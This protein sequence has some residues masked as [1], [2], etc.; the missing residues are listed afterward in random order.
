MEDLANVFITMRKLLCC[1]FLVSISGQALA[2]VSSQITEGYRQGSLDYRDRT[3]Y[4]YDS[5]G[6]IVL[7]D[8]D[9]WHGSQWVD[10][11]RN[12]YVY[13]EKGR[14]IE[15]TSFH[16][17]R[18][19]WRFG[20]R[21]TWWFS[22]DGRAETETVR[23]WE[24]SEWQ[25]LFQYTRTRDD[26]GRLLSSNR[27]F[28]IA[29]E[30]QNGSIGQHLTSTLRL[31]EYTQTGAVFTT[32]IWR[33]GSWNNSTRS[34][35]EY[36]ELGRATSSLYQDW[37]LESWTNRSRQEFDRIENP[38]DT[39]RIQTSF[40]WENEAWEPDRRSSSLG[41]VGGQA[42]NR[43]WEDWVDSAWVEVSRA[44]TQMGDDGPIYYEK[45]SQVNGTWLPSDR[46][47]WH[48][49]VQGREVS[50]EWDQWD[51]NGWQPTQKIFSFYNQSTNVEA[52]AIDDRVEIALYPNPARTSIQLKGSLPSTSNLKIEVFDLLGRRVSTSFKLTN[53]ELEAGYRLNISQLTSG[54]YT[55]RI[56]GGDRFTSLVFVKL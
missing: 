14:R 34:I 40:N 32:Q 16:P 1:I 41:L 36:D 43:I 47:T 4:S 53:T 45:E 12:E 9:G 24:D 48:Y 19:G 7:L 10:C 22:K 3:D 44:F 8:V 39:S 25:N 50:S 56:S 23:E 26:R 35:F 30:W 18:P 2:Q 20:R 29:G 27:K 46:W 38:A 51:G 55:V 15:R 28:W 13:D 42:A 17:L 33:D 6:N 31:R 54:V 5:E 49:D 52:Y 11:C 21:T 37:E